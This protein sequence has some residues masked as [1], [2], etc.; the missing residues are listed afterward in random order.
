MD[1]ILEGLK[2]VTERV[3]MTRMQQRKIKRGHKKRK[4]VVAD[5]EEMKALEHI[6]GIVR[7]NIAKAFMLF[8]DIESPDGELEFGPRS[9]VS[10]DE[11]SEYGL[12]VYASMSIDNAMQMADLGVDGDESVVTGSADLH[13]SG[14]AGK[15]PQILASLDYDTSVD[16]GEGEVEL[17]GDKT[18]DVDVAIPVSRV[19]K[20]RNLQDLRKVLAPLMRK[21]KETPEVIWYDWEGES[22]QPHPDDTDAKYDAWK[23]EGS[24]RDSSGR[25]RWRG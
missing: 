22:Q 25:P 24:P 1:E 4:K 7:G 17:Y 19:M 9:S 2:A 5:E 10:M 15:K 8:G 3:K 14:K 20:A 11:P 16:Q 21:A 18:W 6:A 23:D 12:G 13:F